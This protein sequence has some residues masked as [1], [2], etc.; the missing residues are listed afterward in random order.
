MSIGSYGG[1]T[2]RVSSK[3]IYTFSNLKRTRTA[4][5]KEHTRYGQK[6]ISQFIAPGLD[7]ITMDIHLDAS[8][9]VKPR[10]LM[11]KWG[12]LLENGY[13]DIFVIGGEQVGKNEW[14][15]ESISEAWNIIMNKGEVVSADISITISEYLT[16]DKK[17]K[18][19]MKKSSKKT[20]TTKKVATSKNDLVKGGNYK[21]KSI[22][23]GFYTAA[24][25]ASQ[26]AVNRTGKVYPGSYYIFNISQGQV[27]V[28]KVKGS[29]GSWINPGKNK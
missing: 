6:P 10:A 3:K 11:D 24:E 29:P 2:F 27:N 16:S 4:E 7:S 22:L 20:T 9:G 14:K 15:I 5:W 1:M 8:L 18:K 12:K 28:T 26:T 25:S 19:D 21:V 23:T 17:D 13:H